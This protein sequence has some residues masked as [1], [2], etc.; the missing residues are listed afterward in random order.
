MT[1]EIVLTL[2]A[3]G[4]LTMVLIR[5]SGAPRPPTWLAIGHGLIALVGLG[6]LVNA[7]MQTTIPQME[8]VSL[9]L[10]VLAA[11][12]GAAIF[13]LFHLRDKALP[14]PLILGHGLIALIALALLIIY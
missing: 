8:Q 4:G 12:G 6:L 14:I 2:A 11:L 10:F 3:L 5:L 13:G 9:G 1:P 7:A